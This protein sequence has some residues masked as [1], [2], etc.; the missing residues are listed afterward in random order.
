MSTALLPRLRSRDVRSEPTDLEPVAAAERA[1]ELAP[2]SPRRAKVLA[3]EVL[4]TAEAAQDVEAVAIAE[5]AL[6]LAALGLRDGDAAVL[7]LR[8]AVRI[9]ERAELPLR[10]AE[11]RM[12]LG[13]ALLYTGDS[14]GAFRE[15]DARGPRSAAW[16]ARGFSCSAQSSSTTTIGSTRHWTATAARSSSSAGTATGSG[17]HGR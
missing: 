5:R 7:H 15:I 3:E 9:A 16:Q 11:A 2:D 8:R 14:R 12:S 17:R 6:G 4:R 1:I 13:R 10:A